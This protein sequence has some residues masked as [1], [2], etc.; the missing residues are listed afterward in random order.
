V[1]AG[2]DEDAWRHA[3]PFGEDPTK[4]IDPEVLDLMYAVAGIIGSTSGQERCAVRAFGDFSRVAFAAFR[5]SFAATTGKHWDRAA[6]ALHESLQMALDPK[7]RGSPS[8][9]DYRWMVCNRMGLTLKDILPDHASPNESNDRVRMPATEVREFNCSSLRKRLNKCL[10]PE[11]WKRDPE[12]YLRLAGNYCRIANACWRASPPKR[13]R[14]DGRPA[15]AK[16]VELLEWA[17]SN[18]LQPM[19][20]SRQIVGLG[21]CPIDDMPP[22]ADTRSGDGTWLFPTRADHAK[23][24]ASWLDRRTK[25]TYE[26]LR[27]VLK[28]KKKDA[29]RAEQKKHN[30]Q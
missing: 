9:F 29:K 27:H 13:E 19:V 22:F 3:S 7:T 26:N 18:G 8:D 2:L 24:F 30:H 11:V 12:V 23:A 6:I 28:N 4:G 16:R 21:R 17:Q 15:N 1:A 5:L 10:P 25:V 14:R 20:L